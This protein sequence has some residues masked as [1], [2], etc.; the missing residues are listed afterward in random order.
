MEFGLNLYSLAGQIKTEEDFLN[1]LIKLKEMGYSYVQLS[2]RPVDGEIAK[3]VSEKAGMPIVLSHSPIARIKDDTKNLVFDHKSFNCNRIGLGYVNYSTMSHQEKVDKIR[4]LQEIAENLK[5]YD[6]EFHY[7]NHHY[8][9]IKLEDGKTIYD[10][11]IE[12]CPDVKFIMDTFWLQVGGVNIIE[13]VNKAKG[14]ID[15]VHLKDYTLTFKENGV[16]EA[17]FAPVGDGNINFKQIIPEM[18]KAGTKYFLV[19][20][21]DATIYDNPFEQVER[22]IKYLKANF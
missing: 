10:H 16:H 17:K 2:G 8:E 1:T 15:C 21:D 9:F 7:H 14:R 3:R 11:I 19:E 18:V 6:A 5:Q 13:Y 22:S 12:E 20:Q 4:E